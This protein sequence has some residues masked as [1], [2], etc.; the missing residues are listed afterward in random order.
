[1]ENDKKERRVYGEG[2][3][4]YRKSD[5]RWVA[6]FKDERMSKPKIM[7]ANSEKEVKKKL[8]EYKKEIAGKTVVEIKK[9][10][11]EIYM[12]NWLLE[13]IKRKKLKP[14]SIDTLEGTLKNQ[15][16][17]HIGNIQIASLRMDD[18]ENMIFDL[19]N[20][21]L[22]YSRIKK[23]YDA[24]NA[25]FKKG[26][27]NREL[28]YNPCEGV[29]LP[30]NT[31]KKSN[32]IIFFDEDEVNKICKTAISTYD[33]GK[34]IFRL[35]WTIPLLF[36]AGIRVSELLGLTW[37]DIDIIN[38]TMTISKTVVFVNDRDINT[39]TKTKRLVQESTKTKSS[40]RIIPLNKKAMES[41]EK[42][43][44]ITGAFEYLC[45]TS[46]GKGIDPSSIDR[47]FKLILKKSGI[48]KNCGV[49]ACRHTFASSLFK[50]GVDVKYVSELLGHSN[51]SITYNIYI[52]PIKEQKIKMVALL[53][54]L[55][56]G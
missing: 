26:L 23:A 52:H 37:S 45:T 16:F 12:S 51:I 24:V 40:A 33:S 29:D 3:T 14:R 54:E 19:E 2:S 22:S 42:L 5:N 47:M 7:Y 41:I 50:Q 21:G 34:Y 11:V 44:E 10:S 38:K 4:F 39:K 56:S 18:I 35:G 30:A 31:K 1:M 25:C 48:E 27:I 15:V 49:H 8:R 6:K 20:K 9:Q 32:D 17:P 28:E 13:R 55:Y 36:N 43:R 53:D 46:N